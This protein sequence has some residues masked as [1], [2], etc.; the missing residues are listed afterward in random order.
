[1][2][3]RFIDTVLKQAL[4]NIAKDREAILLELFRD[5][6]GIDEKT[7]LDSIIDVFKNTPPKV[8][9]G[10][11]RADSDF[12]LYS[13]TLGTEGASEGFLEDGA[14]QVEE[15]DDPEF[16]ADKKAEIWNHSYSVWCYAEHPDV[17]GYIYEVA[18]AALAL[19]AH[20]Y[21]IGKGLWNIKLSGMEMAPDPR[22]APE[23][24][25]LR[26]LVLRCDKEFQ[27]LDRNSKIGKAFKVSGIHVDNSGSSRDVGGVKTKV[28]VNG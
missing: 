4:A 12:P 23:N 11:P 14:G 5:E 7:E 15:D 19:N 25:F 16:G 20:D 28:K 10:Y 6:L 1:M 9:L 26:Q 2:I 21:L 17:C 13:I 18:K 8:I 27:L 22:Y 3:Q 24:L